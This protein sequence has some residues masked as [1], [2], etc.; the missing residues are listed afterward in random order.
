MSVLNIQ[1]V[2]VK[3]RALFSQ[4][5]FKIFSTK[6]PAMASII[7][8]IIETIVDQGLS[9]LEKQTICDLVEIA[10]N[11]E[12]RGVEGII[13][14]T[15][16]ALGGYAI[17]IASAKSKERPFFIYDVFG[18]ILPPS[19]QMPRIVMRLQQVVMLMEWM[20]RNIMGMKIIYILELYSHLRNF[21]L[22]LKRITLI[23]LKVYINI[24]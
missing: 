2:V 4:I 3:S 13:V 23:S 20:G 22:S 12:R 10:M 1:K 6:N 24:P 5:D 7:E 15:G 9:Y 19:E 11:N 18:T 17:A 8:T 14:E 16:C 21:Q